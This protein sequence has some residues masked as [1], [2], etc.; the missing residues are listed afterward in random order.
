M[1]PETLAR[2][3]GNATSGELGRIKASEELAA[4][5]NFFAFSKPYR[6]AEISA[7]M[8]LVIEKSARG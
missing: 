7:K 3:A 2:S 6:Y 8:T 1:A 4:A 5:K